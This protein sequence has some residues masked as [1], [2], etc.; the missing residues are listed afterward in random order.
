MTEPAPPVDRHPADVVTAMVDHV[1]ELAETWPRWDLQPV[2]V[3]VDAE[4]PRVYTPHKAVRRVADHL[5]DHLAE[6]EA[7]LVGRPTEPDRWH[8]SMVTT[9][10]DLAPFTPDDLDEAKSR[11]RRLALIWEVRLRS[12]TDQQLDEPAV[13][14][15]TGPQT[16]TEVRYVRPFPHL[17]HVGSFA[18]IRYG[19]LAE[20]A[21]FDDALLVS[22]DGRVVE[23]T[24]ANVGFVSGQEVVWPD[25]PCLRGVT[26]QLLDVGLVA[27]GRGVRREAV[28]IDSV[29][30]FDAA[31]VANSVGVSP[32]GRIGAHEFRPD[33]PLVTELVDIY[34]AVPWT[35]I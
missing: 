6:I 10:S 34:S 11:L 19:L 18:Q 20:R 30:D 26:W 27:R 28:T 17:K 1:L 9:A 24:T 35:A 8:G 15:P 29:G 12:L 3:Q 32:V 4:P 7:R 33:H 31:F 14:A 21:G 13:E 22:D 23:T 2:E 5:L 25:A 16:L